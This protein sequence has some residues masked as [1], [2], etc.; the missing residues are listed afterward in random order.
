MTPSFFRQITFSSDSFHYTE[1]FSNT[2]HIG[3]NGYMDTGVRNL[4]VAFFKAN[5]SDL[6]T[7]EPNIYQIGLYILLNR[8][9]LNM[10][11][12]LKYMP[13]WYKSTRAFYHE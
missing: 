10:I 1:N 2:I 4:E 9:T 13:F 7:Y 11:L 6:M 5:L 12:R 8:H 3:S